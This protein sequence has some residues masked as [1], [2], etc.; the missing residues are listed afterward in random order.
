MPIEVLETLRAI[1]CSGSIIISF[2]NDIETKP[3]QKGKAMVSIS[4][5]MAVHLKT[6]FTQCSRSDCVKR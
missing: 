1:G 4:K 2:R 6:D 3:T 5:E